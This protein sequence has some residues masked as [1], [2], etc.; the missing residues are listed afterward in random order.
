MTNTTADTT[1]TTNTNTDEP[2][3]PSTKKNPLG[4]LGMGAAA[5]A[6]CCA[7]PILA[8]LAAAGLFTATG[9]AL[10]G[11]LGL[12]VLVPAVAWYARRR[13]R[14]AACAARTQSAMS[15]ELGRRS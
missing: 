9:I 6:A 11:V 8:F 14:M 1:A 5:C 13:R 15:V 7:G 3:T 10:F 2:S 4:I 12:L